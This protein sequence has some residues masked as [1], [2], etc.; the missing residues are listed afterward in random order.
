ML[1]KAKI[2]ITSENLPFLVPIIDRMSDTN[3]EVIR[4]VLPFKTKVN[5]EVPALS[6]AVPNIAIVKNYARKRGIKILADE[7][8]KQNPY[9]PEGRDFF[10]TNKAELRINFQKHRTKPDFSIIIPVF[11]KKDSLKFVLN[12]FLKQDYPKKGY[13][14]IV[15]D[16][17]SN[18]GTLESI[19][20]IK[21]SCNF[22]YFYWPRKEI[23]IREEHK[24]F[25]KFYNRAGLTRNIGIKYAQGEIILFNDSDILVKLDCLRRHKKYHD[26]Y[27]NIIVRGF[28]N[29]LPENFK[30]NFKKIGDFTFLD[31]ISS[32]EKNKRGKRLHCHLYNL[33]NKGWQRVIT[34]NLS[35]RKR[36]LEKVGG[37]S[38][39]FVFWG[40]EDVDLGYRLSR[41]KMKFIFDDKIK[42]YHLWHSKESGIDFNY[43]LVLWINTNIL[44]R[45]YFDEKIY[46]IFNDVIMRKLDT[47]I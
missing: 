39:D 2:I 25:A 14:I 28:R 5:D 4:L 32:P 29:F 41:L 26:R 44:Y 40:G 38:K 47:L 18:D 31:K 21:P 27:S 9:L 17:G 8:L 7:N 34:A 42:T 24:K 35:V 15:V 43:F 20:N 22:K 23:K 10:D 1:K 37:F 3:I 19:K 11:N 13:E 45:K 12:N 6:D 46:S 33:F 36:Y 30:P 16:D